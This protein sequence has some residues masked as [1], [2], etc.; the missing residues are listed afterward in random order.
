MTHR[1]GNEMATRVPPLPPPPPPPHTFTFCCS[2]SG[3]NGQSAHRQRKSAATALQP[4]SMG[5][6]SRLAP[7]SPAHREEAGRVPQPGIP[8]EAAN[9]QHPQLCL[10][11]REQVNLQGPQSHSDIEITTEKPI[12]GGNVARTPPPPHRRHM[13]VPG[14][15]HSSSGVGAALPSTASTEL[16]HPAQEDAA[17]GFRG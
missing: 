13:I 12:R 11:L 3:S 6:N 16:Q 5:A 10:P 1:A 17:R 9:Q 15:G 8:D 2:S 7:L 4:F 14:R